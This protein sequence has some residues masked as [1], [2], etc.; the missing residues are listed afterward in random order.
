MVETETI[1][2]V[3]DEEPI[4]DAIIHSLRKFGY[5]FLQ[6][7][8][9]EAAI[10]ILNSERV[11]CVISDLR[12]PGMGGHGLVRHCGRQQPAVPII[13]IS[14]M[15]DKS[16]LVELMR[17]GVSDYV[18]KPW[19]ASELAE[20]VRRGLEKGRQPVAVAAAPVMAQDP[21]EAPKDDALD[22]QLAI[23]LQ[24]KLFE[25]LEELRLGNIAIPTSAK[26]AVEVRRV[27][28]SR[29]ASMQAL[30]EVIERDVS[31]AGRVIQLANSAFYRSQ[32]QVFDLSAAVRRIGFGEIVQVVDTVVIHEYYAVQ[33]PLISEL[34]QGLWYQ[35]W[36]RAVMMRQ[37]AQ[38]VPDIR[39]PQENAYLGGLFCD[40]GV[41]FLLRVIA[42]DAASLPREVMI[43]FVQQHHSTAGAAI[44]RQ[45][46][47]PKDVAELAK[48]HHDAACTDNLV[49][50]ARAAEQ[51]IKGAGYAT[52]LWTIDSN[53]SHLKDVGLS[54]LTI[55]TL[56]N[57]VE[58]YLSAHA[59]DFNEN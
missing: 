7:D 23:A 17:Q 54:H 15:A 37:V 24:K 8:S 28:S 41:A 57:R 19:S 12:M 31:I 47:L 10:Q 56:K 50:L 26:I 51:L 32:G 27:A 20:A 52:K 49:R 14:G 43:D 42:D 33:Q 4:R 13:V 6:A 30:T 46:A 9:A 2:I 35:T 39:V 53:D 22:P 16:D 25:V 29:T 3:D 59:D 58:K 18:D 5:S 34:M 44:C 45:W 55:A 40:V 21:V 11:N 38:A 1:L 48:L 36:A